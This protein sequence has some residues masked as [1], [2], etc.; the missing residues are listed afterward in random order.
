MSDRYGR[1]ALAALNAAEWFDESRDCTCADDGLNCWYRLTP[2]KQEKER[3][4]YIVQ[5]VEAE[6]ERD[7]LDDDWGL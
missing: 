3:M 5:A 1:L 2:E 7:D 6:D 4:A